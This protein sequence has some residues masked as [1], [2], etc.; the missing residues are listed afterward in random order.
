MIV[1]FALHA[2]GNITSTSRAHWYSGKQK[3]KTKDELWHC[4]VTIKKL[5]TI[6]KQIKADR[7]NNA[8]NYMAQ[9]YLGSVRENIICF[10]Y[11]FEKTVSV[12]LNFLRDILLQSPIIQP[13]TSCQ[14]LNDLHQH[15]LPNVNILTYY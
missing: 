5:H 1:L 14:K 13:H 2:H 6:V 7:R 4:S 11:H 15:R 12:L 3:T 9:A 10:S 8:T